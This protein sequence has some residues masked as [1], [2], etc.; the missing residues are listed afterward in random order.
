[1]QNLFNPRSN[2]KDQKGKN[3]PKN[4]LL[5]TSNN[6][7]KLK[8]NYLA[9]NKKKSAHDWHRIKLNNALKIMSTGNINGV[10]YLL[11]KVELS[12]K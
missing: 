5:G 12:L 8:N 11:K 4:Y 7:F 9:L 3:W 10:Q 6:D 2:K 1:M